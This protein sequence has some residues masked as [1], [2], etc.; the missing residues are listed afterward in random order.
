MNRRILKPTD[1]E[2]QFESI[3]AQRAIGTYVNETAQIA[4]DVVA[5]PDQAGNAGGA[6]S[7]RLSKMTRDAA[8]S[9]V[10]AKEASGGASQAAEG[11]QKRQVGSKG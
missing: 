4:H 3:E 5:C 10:C 6:S 2:R 11:E 8:E 7:S 9:H 1:K